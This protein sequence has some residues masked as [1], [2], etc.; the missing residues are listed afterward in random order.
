MKTWPG[1]MRPS[2][3][4]TVHELSA[5]LYDC[6]KRANPDSRPQAFFRRS[7]ETGNRPLSIGG[8]PRLRFSL[9]IWDQVRRLVA[10]A[11]RRLR[12]TCAS[13]KSIDSRT[14]ISPHV[15]HALRCFCPGS[16][17]IALLHLAEAVV[18]YSDGPLAPNI[19]RALLALVPCRGNTAEGCARSRHEGPNSKPSADWPSGGAEKK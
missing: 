13:D 18:D 6:P 11:A 9:G 7:K 14:L 2:S 15:G 16:R 1:L 4:E 5:L 19:S 17:W 8:G 10:D 12:I 3:R